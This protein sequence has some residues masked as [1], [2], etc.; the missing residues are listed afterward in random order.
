[1]ADRNACSRV[2]HGARAARRGFG[3]TFNALTCALPEPSTF[4]IDV[5]RWSSLSYSALHQ[6]QCVRH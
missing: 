3:L 4:E 5:G 1:M 6:P 2:Q